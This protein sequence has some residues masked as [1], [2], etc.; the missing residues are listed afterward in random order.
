MVKLTIEQKI[1]KHL[2]N[3]GFLTSGG[4]IQRALIDPDYADYLI[5]GMIGETD[6]PDINDDG[7]T[8]GEDCDHTPLSNEQ[9]KE[10]F[11]NDN[12]Q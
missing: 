5:R 8:D 7:S 3:K 11:D 4:D 1:V 12:I 10:V 6:I 2:A 9:I